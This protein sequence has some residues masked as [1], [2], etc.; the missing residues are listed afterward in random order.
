MC[1]R[2]H[3]NNENRKGIYNNFEITARKVPQRRFDLN[4]G[5]LEYHARTQRYPLN[6]K[7]M[8]SRTQNENWIK[9]HSRRLGRSCHVRRRYG[10]RCQAPA[11]LGAIF[12]SKRT[13]MFSCHCGQMLVRSAD[14]VMPNP[15]LNERDRR[16]LYEKTTLYQRYRLL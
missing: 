14:A 1:S 8:H 15:G 12:D 16:L 13:S 5:T 10:P 11:E 3:D 9:P 6:D 4:L 7:T 2:W